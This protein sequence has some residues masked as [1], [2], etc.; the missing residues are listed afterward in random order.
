V[1]RKRYVWLP[2]LLLASCSLF[3]PPPTTSTSRPK[4][5]SRPPTKIE[6]ESVPTRNLFEAFEKDAAAAEKEYTN[7]LLRIEG[8]VWGTGVQGNRVYVDVSVPVSGNPSIRCLF[9]AGAQAEVSGFK[10]GG[11]VTIQ[12]QCVG[13]QGEDSARVTLESCTIVRYRAPK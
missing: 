5:T 7:K 1:S 10:L 13:I 11:E 2:C 9:D 8:K 12:G 3:D 4:K 6:A